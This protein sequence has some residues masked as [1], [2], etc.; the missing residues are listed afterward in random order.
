[1][2][3][4]EFITL[5]GG[6]AALPLAARAQQPAGRVYRVGYLAG[7]SRQ[8]QLYLIKAFDEGLRSLGYRVGQNIVIEYRFADGE[9]NDYPRLRRSWSGSAWTS[10]FPGTL[11]ARLR[12]WRRP[13]PSRL[14]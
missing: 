8:T 6:A 3:R 11:E 4:R 1:M 7:G 9:C 2:K 10:S 14:S 5:I 12:P 13:R